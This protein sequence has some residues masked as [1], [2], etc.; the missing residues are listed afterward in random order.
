LHRLRQGGYGRVLTLPYRGAPQTVSVIKRD[1]VASQSDYSVRHLA[2]QI[3][4]G[5]P[6]KA[7]RDEYLAI[8]YF[9]LSHTRYSRDPRTVELVRSPERVARDILSGRRPSL[10]CDDLSSLI[11]ALIA[12]LGGGCRVVTIAFRNMFHKG[13]RQYSHVFAQAKIPH[14]NQWVTLDPVAGSNTGK[15]HRRGVASKAWGIV[16]PAQ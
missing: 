3:V 14:S 16:G 12:S 10:D 2:E 9:V 11:C 6:S 1:V 8:Y 13:E 5:L 4:Q 7:Y 15:M